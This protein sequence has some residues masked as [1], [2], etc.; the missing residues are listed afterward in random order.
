VLTITLLKQVSVNHNPTQ[1]VLTITLLKQVSVNHN[2]TQTVLT[3][4]LLK[5][6]GNYTQNAS[7][8]HGQPNCEWSMVNPTVSGPW[9]TQLGSMVNPTGVHGEPN[10]G[11]W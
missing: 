8:L 3:I 6:T 2:P 1:T 4:T 9:S 11:P 7:Q 10:W 5:P